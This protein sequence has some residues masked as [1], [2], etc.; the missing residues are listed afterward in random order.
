[1]D[2]NAEVAESTEAACDVDETNLLRAGR[3]PALREVERKLGQA[4]IKATPRKIAAMPV[5]CRGAMRSF[6]KMAARAT[7]TAP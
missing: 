7:V 2:F 6:K 5:H 3:M 4:F 1:V